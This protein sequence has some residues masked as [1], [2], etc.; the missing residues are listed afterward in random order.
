[1]MVVTVGGWGL[2][3]EESRSYRKQEGDTLFSKKKIFIT[4]IR[5]TV[6]GNLLN[7]ERLLAGETLEQQ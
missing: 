6:V 5:A 7:S 3:A 4:I 2:M 1:M